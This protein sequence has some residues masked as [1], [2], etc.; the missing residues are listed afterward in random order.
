[1]GYLG[2]L[3]SV[4]DFTSPQYAEPSFVN[5]VAAGSVSMRYPDDEAYASLEKL[6]TD[7]PYFLCINYGF[8]SEADVEYAAR[9]IFG[10]TVPINHSA[11]APDSWREWHYYEAYASYS[12][13]P[14]GTLPSIPQP[15]LLE[16]RD[17]GDKIVLQIAHEVL[18]DVFNPQAHVTLR[19]GTTK[20]FEADK[21]N[22]LLN[23]QG[24]WDCVV[25]EAARMEL[26]LT[27]KPD[28]GFWFTG[29]KQLDPLPP[30]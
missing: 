23:P 13:F 2:D 30:S 19:D 6:E 1:M 15:L 3:G 5:A 18:S 12:P 9:Q 24:F 17:D 25:A 4:A 10:D 11:G 16:Y 14:G 7:A 8:I 28:G 27:K 22:N 29:C 21:D 26:T 20:A